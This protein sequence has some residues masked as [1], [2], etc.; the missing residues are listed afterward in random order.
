LHA[1]GCREM[2]GKVVN[3]LVADGVKAYPL[4]LALGAP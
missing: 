3:S 2:V 1:L 4:N